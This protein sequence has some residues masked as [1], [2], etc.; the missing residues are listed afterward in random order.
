[1]ILCHFNLMSLSKEGPWEGSLVHDTLE[2]E[3]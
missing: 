3:I 2:I 1:M